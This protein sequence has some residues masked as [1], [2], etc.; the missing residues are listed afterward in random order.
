MRDKS[1]EDMRIRGQKSARIKSVGLRG[2]LT[3]QV[4]S[5]VQREERGEPKL[6]I[7]KDHSVFGRVADQ[8]DFGFVSRA[9]EVP[10]KRLYCRRHRGTT[11]TTKL[12][13]QFQIPR[14][15]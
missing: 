2:S 5:T 10:H 14:L 8:N 11:T 1:Q 6:K 15:M 7:R 9:A 4:I 12:E 3:Y 13:S